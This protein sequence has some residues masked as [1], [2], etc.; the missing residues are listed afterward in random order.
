[1]AATTQTA[2]S[3][4]LNALGF[5]AMARDVLTETD[6]GNLARYARIIIKQSPQAAR[7]QLVSSFRQLRVIA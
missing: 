4:L 7:A 6:S 5:E 3:A 1:M 2:L